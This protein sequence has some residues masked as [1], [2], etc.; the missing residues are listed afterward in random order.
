LPLPFGVPDRGE[1][2]HVWGFQPLSARWNFDLHVFCDGLVE[3][4]NTGTRLYRASREGHVPPFSSVDY[5]R[6]AAECVRLAQLV[7]DPTDKARLL[8]MAETF[9]ELAEKHQPR[10]PREPREKDD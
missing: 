9:R 1:P 4:Q 6:Y 3:E 2:L 10:A 7:D 8:N 5:R